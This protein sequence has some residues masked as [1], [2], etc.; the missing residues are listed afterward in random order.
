MYLATMWQIAKRSTASCAVRSGNRSICISVRDSF[1]RA[2]RHGAASTHPSSTSA[3]SSRRHSL[4][5]RRAAPPRPTPA[6]VGASSPATCDSY[7]PC[8]AST[9]TS[10]TRL[11]H[12]S[13]CCRF[14]SFVPTAIGS[15]WRRRQDRTLASISFIFEQ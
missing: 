5:L 9:A 3:S 12:S 14:P 7:L 13:R 2:P 1:A 15:G 4:L 8:S 10:F 11:G 6:A